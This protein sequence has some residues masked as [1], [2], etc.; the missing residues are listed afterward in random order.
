MLKERITEMFKEIM[1]KER[2]KERKNKG[3]K[4]E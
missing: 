4:N 2:T 1:N 3:K